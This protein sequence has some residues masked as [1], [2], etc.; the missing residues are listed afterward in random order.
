MRKHVFTHQRGRC[1]R[2]HTLLIESLK[3]YCDIK[4]KHFLGPKHTLRMMEEYDIE[5]FCLYSH[6]V[7][8]FEY[9]MMRNWI[10]RLRTVYD[11]VEKEHM[12]WRVNRSAQSTTKS[13]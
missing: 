10:A 12:R 7:K 8:W 5:S 4:Q 11:A 9:K 2:W 1:Y 13:G 6:A 3:I